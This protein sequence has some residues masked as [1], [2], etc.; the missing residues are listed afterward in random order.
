[1]VFVLFRFDMLRETI[2]DC[3]LDA[4]GKPPGRR[5]INSI[6]SGK[7]IL[8]EQPFFPNETSLMDQCN[9]YP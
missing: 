9:K 6:R 4:A 8:F 5:V 2:D 1:M 7:I 3:D